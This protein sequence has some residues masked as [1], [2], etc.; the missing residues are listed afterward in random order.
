MQKL[1]K[2]H[3]MLTLGTQQ[4]DLVGIPCTALQFT[5]IAIE[6]LLVFI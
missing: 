1:D 2:F 4:K 3:Y 6:C 5:F